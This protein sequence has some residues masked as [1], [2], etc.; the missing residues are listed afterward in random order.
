MNFNAAFNELQKASAPLKQRLDVHSDNIIAIEKTLKDN[1][2]NIP[3]KMLALKEDNKEYFL[4]YE[5]CPF[6]KSYRL[7]HTIKEND[8]VVFSKPLIECKL[9]VRLK[10]AQFMVPF[11]RAFTNCLIEYTQSIEGIINAK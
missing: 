10:M 4:S 9:E 6:S 3:F 7:I 8:E 11:I 2:T 1:R 5:I